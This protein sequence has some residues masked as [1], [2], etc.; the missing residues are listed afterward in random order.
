MSPH[1]VGGL[2]A[3]LVPSG[4]APYP[5]ARVLAICCAPPGVAPDVL[6][7][8]RAAPPD[9]PRYDVLETTPG[10]V[11]FGGKFGFGRARW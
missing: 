1:T 4:R 2:T 6:F 11:G 7:S 8:E 5:L 10:H 9:G 3:L